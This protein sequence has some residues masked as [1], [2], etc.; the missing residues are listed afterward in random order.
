[1]VLVRSRRMGSKMAIGTGLLAGIL[2]GGAAFAAAVALLPPPPAPVIATPSPLVVPSTPLAPTAAPS[3][4][5]SAVPSASPAVEPSPTPSTPAS[6]SQTFGIGGQATNLR[7]EN[8]GGG[9]VGLLDLRRKPA[10]VNFPAWA[11]C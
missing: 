7:L 1:M 8:A 3:A 4:S 5:A 9:S 11:P 10:W 2:V 6:G